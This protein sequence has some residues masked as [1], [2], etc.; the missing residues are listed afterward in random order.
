MQ[1][2]ERGGET[3]IWGPPACPPVALP[4]QLFHPQ[5]PGVVEKGGSEGEQ[6]PLHP[7]RDQHPTSCAGSPPRS[8]G[9]PHSPKLRAAQSLG[10]PG[11]GEDGFFRG[12]TPFNMTLG[13]Q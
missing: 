9:D 1:G 6:L 8:W 13:E 3:H 12:Q 5:I 4:L 10:T 11:T 7:P 2:R